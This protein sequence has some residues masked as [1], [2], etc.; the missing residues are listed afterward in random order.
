MTRVRLLAL[1]LPALLLSDCFDQVG[2]EGQPCNQNG[3][4]Q[5]SLVC[6]EDGICVRDGT[7]ECDGKPAGEACGDSSSTE[8][9]LPDKCDV[10]GRCLP[11]HMPAGTPCGDQGVVCHKDDAC[12][13]AGNCFDRGY[14]PEGTQCPDNL[15]CNGVETC[16]GAGFCRPGPGDPC[17]PPTVCNESQDTCTGCNS[18]A[19]CPVCMK[20][21]FGTNDCENQLEGE[22]LKSECDPDECREDFCDGKGACGARPDGTDCGDDT[23]TECDNPDSCDGRGNCSPRY[24]IPGTPCGDP[25]DNDCD[26]PDTC[27]GSGNCSANHEPSETA[28]SDGL[29]CN[30]LETCD[31]AGTCLPGPGDPCIPPTVCSEDLDA[32]VGCISHGDCA[33]CM[34]CDPGSSSCEN[35]TALEDLKDE[36]DV[37]ECATGLCDGAGA[38]GFEPDGTPCTDTTPDDCQKAGCDGS[39]S[40]NQTNGIEEEETMCDDGIFCNGADTCD[41][42]GVC[43]NHAGDPCVGGLECNRSCNESL[44]DC[45]DVAG[46]F[47]GSPSDTEC[48]NQDTCDGSGT[49]LVNH[50]P[51]GTS[52]E[53]GD[54]C[55]AGD[56]CQGGICNS[57]TPCPLGCNNTAIPP[58]CYEI[59]PS[60][61]GHDYLCITGAPDL[62]LPSN[63][64]VDVNTDD[65]TVGG[66]VVPTA[67]WVIQGSGAR[68]ILVLSFS[69]IAVPQSTVVNVSGSYPLALIACGDVEINGM[70]NVSAQQKQ[71]GP[72]GYDGG[73]GNNNSTWA[74]PGYGYGGGGGEPGFRET[75]QPYCHTPGGGGGFGRMG[76]DGGDSDAPG[77]SPRQGGAGGQENGTASLV[78]LLGG[79]GGG[80]GA[81]RYYGA[82]GGGGG[83]A[84]QLTAGGSV[85][86]GSSGGIRASGAG[87]WISQ[88][89]NFGGGGG[90]GAGGAILVEGAS[91]Q[92]HG[93]LTANGGGGGGGRAD[94]P[95]WGLHC[96]GGTPRPGEDGPYEYRQ[97]IGG[98]GCTGSSSYPAGDGGRGGAGSYVQGEPG[99]NGYLGGGGGAAAGR[100]RLNSFQDGNTDTAGAMISPVY[101]S[102]A[103]SLW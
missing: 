88:E 90:G 89:Q 36:C 46:T 67:Q 56:T 27:D 92:V 64:T 96:P 82:Y 6:N 54:N 47:C 49:C 8:C 31:G 77:Y 61:V 71:G 48:D 97:A 40:C 95:A 23:D 85:L 72:G 101:T 39:G 103:V 81:G 35:Q 55:T 9:T 60:N 37:D 51:D 17:P 1:A 3:Q 94:Y 24:E 30:G 20:C 4:C 98:D 13:G 65:G 87:G 69:S 45:Y 7:G 18:H 21:N 33:F 38:C 11:N 79:S 5:P 59:A 102:G 10:D 26:N 66:N 78:P 22:D 74:Q 84:V 25:N 58:R 14:E 28:C 42:V 100:I 12:D 76:G 29:F 62:T 99:E 32:C 34:K 70:I 50:E 68:D 44:D 53:D 75:S 86:I 93:K 83:G 91:V 80:G 15:F 57:G 63:T 73:E 16:D 2:G 19:D 43:A 41:G 52:C